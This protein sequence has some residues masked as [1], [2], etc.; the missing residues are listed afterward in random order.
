MKKALNISKWIIQK[1]I[2]FPRKIKL[3]KGRKKQITVSTLFPFL[4]S[5]CSEW[6]FCFSWKVTKSAV[7]CHICQSGSADKLWRLTWN[8]NIDF[9]MNMIHKLWFY[10]IAFH[11]TWKCI[12][13]RHYFL[14]NVEHFFDRKQRFKVLKEALLLSF[15]LA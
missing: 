9:L 12:D 15:L 10:C 3:V 2:S 7:N 1:R 14:C 11:V 13:F 8:N 4:V 5:V 6:K